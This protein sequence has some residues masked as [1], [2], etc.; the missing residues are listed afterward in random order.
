MQDL[1]QISFLSGLVQALDGAT[2]NALSN[3]E[4]Q[5]GCRLPVDYRELL[6]LMNGFSLDNGLLIY[7]TDELLERNKTFEVDIYAPGYFAIGDDSGGR[8]V[9][10]AFEHPG[11]FLV[12]QGSLAP[13][14]MQRVA[15]SV[16][17]WLK[18]GCA[19]EE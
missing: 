3:L 13:R 8:V 15:S 10:I 16:S 12:D 11:V 4:S 14:D 9:L 1:S 17:Q 6:Q 19:I 2:D 5:I 7:G 18:R